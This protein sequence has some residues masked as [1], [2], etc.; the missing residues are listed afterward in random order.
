MQWLEMP[1]LECFLEVY[2]IDHLFC[3][4]LRKYENLN[5]L[6]ISGC[7]ISTLNFLLETPVLETLIVADCCNL[8][9]EDFE[10][11]TKLKLKHLD[12]SHAAITAVTLI[13]VVSSGLATLQAQNVTFSIKQIE[14]LVS[15][16]SLLYFSFVI[17][18]YH[19][20]QAIKTL[21]C[22]Y[23]ECNLLISHRKIQHE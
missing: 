13:R 14:E 6:G 20:F 22:Q 10:V 2:S 7:I 4:Y 8:I 18:S 16:N 3:T 19:A 5:Y 1:Y 15:S 12:V 17:D 9:G 21:R 11:L 23:P